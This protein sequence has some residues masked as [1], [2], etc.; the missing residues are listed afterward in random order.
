M[1]I[2]EPFKMIVYIQEFDKYDS[3]GNLLCRNT[4]CPNHPKSPYKKNTAL[5]NVIKIFDAG[6][7]IIFIGSVLDQIFS[8]VI[9]IPVRYFQKSLS[10]YIQ[11]EICKNLKI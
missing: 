11:K 6:I 10:L 8:N 3:N 4:M 5:R 7:I 2:K 9:I 1:T